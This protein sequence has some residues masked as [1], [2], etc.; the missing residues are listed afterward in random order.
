[1]AQRPERIRLLIVDDDEA[2]CETLARRFEKQ[3]LQVRTAPSGEDLFAAELAPCDVALLDLNM[4][5]MTGLSCSRSSR[6]SSRSWR[7]SC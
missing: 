7:P 6:N 4:P 3:G 2:L 5:G 1:M